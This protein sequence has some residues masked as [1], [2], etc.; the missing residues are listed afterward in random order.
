MEKTFT[1]VVNG[2]PRTVT[3]DPERPLLEVLR[4][5][6]HL[7]GTKDGCG[8]GQC[9]ALPPLVDGRSVHS[10]PDVHQRSGPA[11]DPDDR[12]LGDR[13]QAASGP[14]RHFWPK[15]RLQCGHGTP[16]MV[17]AVVGLLNDTP[18]PTDDE[19][20]SQ[21]CRINSAAAAATPTS[22]PPSSGLRRT[23]RPRCDER[24]PNLAR[25]CGALE[26]E[27]PVERLAYEF[28]F[29]WRKFVQVLVPA[30]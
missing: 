8:E 1:F 5:D 11:D 12:G 6:L 3:T 29:S 23:P 14:Q 4:E 22:S 15:M 13:R 30:C 10:C 20:L 26:S 24:E 9:G 18:H 27:E 2:Q 28:A 19:I 16:G 21:A 17:V 25:K 7:T